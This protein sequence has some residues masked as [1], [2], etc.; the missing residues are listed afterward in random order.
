MTLGK[1]LKAQR[2][3]KAVSLREMATATG[4]SLSSLN[5]YEL[6][7]CI[8]QPQQQ[9]ALAQYFEVETKVI[10]NKIRR[11]ELNDY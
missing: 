8:P 9:R 2:T 1:W 3:L 11:D 7:K 4:I 5:H 6:D 10:V